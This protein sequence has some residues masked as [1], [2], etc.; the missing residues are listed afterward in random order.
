MAVGVTPTP[1]KMSALRTEPQEGTGATEAA[2]AIVARVRVL[3][4]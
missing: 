1:A 4:V 3:P 2:L